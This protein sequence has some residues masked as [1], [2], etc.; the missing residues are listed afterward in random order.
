MSRD[1]GS[2]SRH[3][4]GAHRATNHNP[5]YAAFAVMLN[6]ARR[7]LVGNVSPQDSHFDAE[8]LAP[9]L[10]KTVHTSSRCSYCRRVT[11]VVEATTVA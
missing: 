10:L 4:F 9:G 6:S 1:R 7:S 11:R 5:A 3:S 2:A 8:N